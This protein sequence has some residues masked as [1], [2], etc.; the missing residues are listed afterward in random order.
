MEP[1]SQAGVLQ[2]ILDRLCRESDPAKIYKDLK[3]L[4]SVPILRDSLAAI[5]FRKTIKSLKRQQLLVQFVKDLVAKWSPGFLPGPQPE[6]VPLDF[7]SVRSPR[8]AEQ[9]TA[10]EETSQEQVFQ[11]SRV[12]GRE[13][14]LVLSNYSPGTIS[15]L[16]RSF[17]SN[18]FSHPQAPQLRNLDPGDY[19]S[20][21]YQLAEQNPEQ[22]RTHSESFEVPWQ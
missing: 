12:A 7:G 8:T 15:C 9:S 13:V 17:K 20:S 11:V 22:V 16:S 3:E 5:G 14:F 18:T 21:K 19:W 4:S 1:G 10:L 2:E 6:Q